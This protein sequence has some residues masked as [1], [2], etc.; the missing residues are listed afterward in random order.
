MTLVL[1][2]TNRGAPP[3]QGGFASIY[4][5]RDSTTGLY[6]ALKHMRLNADSD[7][8]REVQHEAKTMAKL[9]G[10][11]NIL[12]LYAVSFAG[13]TGQETDGFMLLEYCPVSQEGGA[14][15]AHC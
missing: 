13:P 3:K 11:P 5:S 6:F 14:G 15:W 9:K 4:K 7:A 8:I 12:R 1:T 2:V 10:H